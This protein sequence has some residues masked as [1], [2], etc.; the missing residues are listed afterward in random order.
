VPGLVPS[1]A[2]AVDWIIIGAGT[3]KH[4]TH[5]DASFTAVFHM[6][7][8]KAVLNKIFKFEKHFIKYT[9]TISQLT[10]CIT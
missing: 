7:M 10:I 4:D 5:E 6:A 9:K 3:I 1:Q 8:F 2:L